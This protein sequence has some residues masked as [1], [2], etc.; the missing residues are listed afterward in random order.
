ML[1][2]QIFFGLYQGFVPNS[3][4]SYMSMRGTIKIL[5]LTTVCTG[6][7]AKV[8]LVSREVTVGAIQ[9]KAFPNDLKN[10]DAAETACTKWCVWQG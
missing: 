4:K 2:I 8:Q 10:H 5:C 3:N 9:Y 7:A 6:V 1:R